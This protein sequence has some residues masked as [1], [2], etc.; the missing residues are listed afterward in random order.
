MI[1]IGKSL[2]Q[3]EMDSFRVI[4]GK[5]IITGATSLMAGSLLLFWSNL[6]PVAILG[7]ASAFATLGV[8]GTIKLIK[9]F[10]RKQLE[11]EVEEDVE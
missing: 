6:T 4:L 10:T 8:E 2:I 1:S 9:D 11:K 7:I 3:Q 5:A